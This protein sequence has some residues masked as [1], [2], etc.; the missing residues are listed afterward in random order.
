MTGDITQILVEVESGNPQAAERLFAVVYEELRLLA[1]A[2]FAK[3]RPDHTL[4]AT[5]LVHEAYLKL[6]GKQNEQLY[7]SSG[8]FFAAAATAMRRILVD[9]ARSRQTVKRGGDRTREALQDVPVSTSDDE[10]LALDEAVRKLE[11]QDPLKA[12]LVE[13]RFFGGLTNDDAAKSLGISPSTADRHWT[14][15]R[16][17]LQ[18]E[19][20][21]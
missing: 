18:A 15:A 9:S 4:Q 1:S 2:E 16:A 14:F 11:V 21:G 8:R 13:L 20:R 17:W 5:A 12:Q 10:L 3:E 19:V 6:V 7:S